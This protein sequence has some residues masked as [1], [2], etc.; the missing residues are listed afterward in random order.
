MLNPK[1][2]GCDVKLLV[3]EHNSCLCAAENLVLVSTYNFIIYVASSFKCALTL[4]FFSSNL[5]MSLQIQLKSYHVNTTSNMF[6][7]SVRYW[8]IVGRIV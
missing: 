6:D 7:N 5:L 8:M 3:S 2:R 1:L 4:S